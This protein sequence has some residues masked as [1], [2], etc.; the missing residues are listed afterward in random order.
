MNRLNKPIITSETIRA[1]EDMSFLTHA[2]IFDDLLI[3]SQRDIVSGRSIVMGTFSPPL[4]V[5]YN[6]LSGR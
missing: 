1:M 3:V 2:L 4:N 5:W 6:V